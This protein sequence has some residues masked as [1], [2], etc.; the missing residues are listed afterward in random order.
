TF[1]T[2][3]SA[4]QVQATSASVYR[5]LV[6]LEGTVNPE[7]EPSACV[8]Q[9]GTSAAYGQEARCAPEALGEAGIG[10]PVIAPL[11]GLAPDTTYHYR[12]LTSN[13][14]GREPGPNETFT[15]EVVA[16][17]QVET[18]PAID[19]TATSAALGGQANP[20]GSATYYIQYGSSQ[21]SLNG[22]ANFAWF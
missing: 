8:F 15:T 20:G 13:P 19:V 22:V 12:L 14:T 18:A 3:S 1:T 21:C 10:V 17:T 5:A 4:P 9:Y 7:F 6:T 2:A 16:P 11:E